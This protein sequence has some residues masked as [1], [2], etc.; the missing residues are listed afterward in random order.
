MNRD[1]E[2]ARGQSRRRVVGQQQ[3]AWMIDGDAQRFHFAVMQRQE[4]GERQEF[5]GC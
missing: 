5:G 4:S 1:L 2:T 3:R